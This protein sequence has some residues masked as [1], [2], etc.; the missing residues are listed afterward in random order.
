MI[1][2]ICYNN[3]TINDNHEDED[4]NYKKN[5]FYSWMYIGFIILGILSLII[6]IYI[7]YSMINKNEYPKSN[8]KSNYKNEIKIDNIKNN[9]KYHHNNNKSNKKKKKK[10]F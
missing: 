8:Y 1:L 7:F 4:K 9:I 5:K 2:D 3:N 6:I 10:R